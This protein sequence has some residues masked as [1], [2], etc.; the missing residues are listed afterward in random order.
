VRALT[1]S[2][3]GTGVEVLVVPTP[4]GP[5]LLVEAH[6]V[7]GLPLLHVDIDGAPADRPVR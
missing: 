2:L 6:P 7:A 3:E 1:W 5:E 4:A